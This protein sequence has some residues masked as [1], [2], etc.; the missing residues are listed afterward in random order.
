MRPMCR[1]LAPLFIVLLGACAA[2]VK[3]APP[4]VRAEEPFAV[5]PPRMPSAVD[6]D[7]VPLGRWAQ[8]AETYL[9]SVTIKERVALV[10]KGADGNLIETTTEMPTGEKTV[11]ATVFAPAPEGGVQVVRNVFQ[12]ADD[13]PMQAPPAAT[14]G[15]AVPTHRPAHAGRRRHDHRACR[16]VPR[17]ALP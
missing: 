10:G 6:L 2:P 13:E 16:D 5:W 17:E 14:R 9:G 15:A 1:R 3:E 11:F 12:V 4:P 8:Y 7:A